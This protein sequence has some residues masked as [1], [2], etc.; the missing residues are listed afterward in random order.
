MLVEQVDAIG[1]QSLQGGFTD[2]ADALRPAVLAFVAVAVAE[3]E[4]GGDHDLVAGGSE[5]M[6]TGTHHPR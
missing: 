3:S 5:G 1:A 2:R 4:L 6:R